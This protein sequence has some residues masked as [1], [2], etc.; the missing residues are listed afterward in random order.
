MSSTHTPSPTPET[1]AQKAVNSAPP[2][3]SMPVA[4][5]LE[6]AE[7]LLLA[8]MVIA[9]FVLILNETL[10]GVALPEIMRDLN[11]TASTAQWTSTGFMLTM[12]VVTPASGF[13]ISRF[14]IRTVF[15][16]A[17]LLFSLGTLVAATAPGIGMLL[18]GRVLQASGTGVMMPLLMTTMMRMVAPSK[19]GQAMGIIGMVISVAPA[20]GPTVSGL[21]L[22]V[23]TWRW[24]FWLVLPIGIAAL[25]VGMKLA[26]ADAPTG[27]N[28]KLDALSMLLSTLGFGG[29]V[30]GLSSMGGS[31]A[32]GGAHLPV[33]PW[34][35]V[36]SA[37]IILAIFVWRQL[38]LQ[39]RGPFM[40]M[41]IFRSRPFTLTV[42]M[43]SIGMGVMLGT[44][45][46]I[47]LYTA[48]VLG[49]SAL[50]TGLMLLPGGVLMAVLS[51]LVGRMSDRFGAR[52]LVLPGAVLLAGSIW[53][54]STFSQTTPQWYIIATYVL[55]TFSLPFINTPMM[56]LG[57][58]SL[59]GELTAFGSSAMTTFQQ[60]SGAAS[61]A[62][63]VALMGIGSA[64]HGGTG[65]EAYMAGVH[66]A[67][68]VA[69][70]MS[71]TSIVVAL[72]LPAG[73][74]AAGSAPMAH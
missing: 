24:L 68:L 57:L 10:L 66:L 7:F 58:G 35:I 5:K 11:I 42:L 50:Q 72:L 17:M 22:G 67:F 49:V 12:A 44:S 40:D 18:T 61:T 30:L 25:L 43:T 70:F 48:N 27:S 45:I 51:P 59:S 21:V 63:F 53:L 15:M 34:V 47:P 13:I 74:Q 6:K 54:M 8:I 9:G 56:G 32:H 2:T 23:G 3:A 64:A 36:I 38:K 14:S 69:A 60:V 20:M 29:L 39:D 4:R 73:K 52:A 19:I 55:M 1:G 71:L 33:N 62:L 65:V 16:G 31:S 46:L 26:P 41:R 37:A 28:Q